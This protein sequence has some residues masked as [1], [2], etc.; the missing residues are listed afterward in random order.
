ML[1]IALGVGEQVVYAE[2][3]MPLGQQSVDQMEEVSLLLR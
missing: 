1:D 3:F 2:H